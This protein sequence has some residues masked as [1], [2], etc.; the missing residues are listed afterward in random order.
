M[1]TFSLTERIHTGSPSA[2]TNLYYEFIA[3]YCSSESSGVFL[4]KQRLN[5]FKNMICSNVYV[6]VFH[7]TLVSF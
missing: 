5:L 3:L 7:I 6:R 2:L 1:A 4:D